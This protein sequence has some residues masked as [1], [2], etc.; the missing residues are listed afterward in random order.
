MAREQR[1]AVVSI[2]ITDDEQAR[3]RKMA[4]ARGTSVSELMRSAAMR[5]V[6]PPARMSGTVS[7]TAST[8]PPAEVDKGIFWDNAE[9]L[10]TPSPGTLII[11]P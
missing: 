8:G 7:T 2:R 9:N 5:E 3:L 4:H 1:G 10:L 11:R 6:E